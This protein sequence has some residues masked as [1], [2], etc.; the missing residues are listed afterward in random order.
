V[1]QSI[2]FIPIFVKCQCDAAPE[3]FSMNRQHKIA[4]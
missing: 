2:A 3:W 4:V 1:K